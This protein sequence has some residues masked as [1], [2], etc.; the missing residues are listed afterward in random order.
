MEKLTKYANIDYI[1][2]NKKIEVTPKYIY[3]WIIMLCIVVFIAGFFA[4]YTYMSYMFNNSLD[5]LV[6]NE[7]YL[8]RE[9]KIYRLVEVSK[10]YLNLYPI[11]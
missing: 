4:G 1:I 8:L 7:I 3:K 11:M 9:D 10:D 5:S 2:H 6:N